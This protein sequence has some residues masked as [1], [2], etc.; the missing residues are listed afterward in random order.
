MLS[1][2]ARAASVMTAISVL[3]LALALYAV[4]AQISEC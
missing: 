2:Y 1:F 3:L 4:I